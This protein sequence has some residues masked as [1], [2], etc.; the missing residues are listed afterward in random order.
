MDFDNSSTAWINFS[1]VMLNCSEL[2]ITNSPRVFLEVS[3]LE[4]LS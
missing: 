3:D 2:M 4:V 1:S